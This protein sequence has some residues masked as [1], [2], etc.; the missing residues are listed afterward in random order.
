M[1]SPAL[2]IGVLAYGALLTVR[3][4]SLQPAQK[5]AQKQEAPPQQQQ[6]QAAEAVRSRKISGAARVVVQICQG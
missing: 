2:L 4:S 1:P 3:D 5:P 6:Q